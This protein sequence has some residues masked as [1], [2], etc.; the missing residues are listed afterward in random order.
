L[1]YCGYCFGPFII[2]SYRHC[3]SFYCI[4]IMYLIHFNITECH[5][6]V[7]NIHNQ[8]R[9]SDHQLKNDANHYLV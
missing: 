4:F 9:A 8:V 1:F 3:L 6:I 7:S 2:S 5:L